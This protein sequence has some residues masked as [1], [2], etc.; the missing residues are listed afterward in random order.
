MNF[1]TTLISCS[2]LPKLM[3]ATKEVKP[4]TD[5]QM[6]E[7]IKL[8]I[9]TER[10]PTQQSKYEAYEKRN[11]TQGEISHISGMGLSCLK[12]IY[13]REKWGKRIINVSKDYVPGILNGSLAE[14]A[15]L[16]LICDL[17]GIQYKKHKDLIKNKYLKGI[18]DCY[19]GV[20]IKKAEK[21]IDIKTCASM[22]SLVA[23]IKDEEVKS[24]FYWQIMGYLAITGAEYGAIYHCVVDYHERII[25]D[26]IN[27]FLHRTKGLGFDGD[28]IDEQVQHIR[29]NLTFKEIPAEQRVVKFE[30]TRDEDAI[31][32]IYE[33]VRFCRQWLNKFDELH[34]NMNIMSDIYS[35][36]Q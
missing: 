19:T 20:S 14:S 7:Y 6:A 29:F 28:Y 24:A 8:S 33:K 18:I 17:D 30:V 12:D 34:R 9:S 35:K 4:L 16:G 27:K 22:H 23:L 15:S 11:K 10:T 32:Q 1:N 21:V 2:Y 5:K 31:K 26:E 36:V 13:L 3:N 25:T